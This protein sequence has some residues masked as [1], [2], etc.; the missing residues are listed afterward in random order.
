[1]SRAR[2]IDLLPRDAFNVDDPLL[3]VDLNNFAFTTLVS[4]TDNLNFV[5]LADGHRAGVVLVA[6][7]LGERCRHDLA[8]N[9]GW[10]RE[11]R[12]ARLTAG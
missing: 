10:G 5:V 11:V 7:L 4:S 6:E 8:T 9:A 12:Q 3:S 1:M 2:T